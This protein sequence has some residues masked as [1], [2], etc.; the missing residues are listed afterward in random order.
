MKTKLPI[1]RDDLVLAMHA[2]LR[3][4][5]AFFWGHTSAKDGSI[6]KACF[7]QWWSRH[8]FEV[9]GIRYPSAEHFMMA[10]KARLFRDD[11]HLPA[12]LAAK[13]PAIAKKLGRQVTG[14]D[15]NLAPTSL[16]HRRTRQRSQV[17]PA[18]GTKTVSPANWR[19]N[20]RRSQP[21][22][23]HLGHR[24]VRRSS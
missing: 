7:S 19:P 9:D 8:A 18:P 1:S 10:E 20:H 13:S 12:I 15:D 5:W 4:K 22:R 16:G 17:H 24:H 11:V 14:F 6:T 3:P 21:L 2:G 23:S